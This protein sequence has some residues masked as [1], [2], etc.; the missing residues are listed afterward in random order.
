[1]L[2]SPRGGG[3]RARPVP[4]RPDPLRDG[5]PEPVGT[6]AEARYGRVPLGRAF[7]GLSA[8]ATHGEGDGR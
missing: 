3:R 2:D 5:G 7:I 4:D 6:A 8:G 1:M